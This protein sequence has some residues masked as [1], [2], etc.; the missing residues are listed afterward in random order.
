MK[1]RAIFLDRDGTIIRDRHFL[2]KPEEV[3]LF[4]GAAKALRRLGEAGFALVVL[5]NQSGVA[6]GLF[7]LAAVAAV[8]DELERQLAQEGISLDG[9]YVCPHHP[10]AESKEFGIACEC[11]K[12]APGLA[13]QAAEELSLN[14]EGSWIVGDKPDDV[15]LSKVLPLHAVL[16]RTGYGR[17]REGEV[18]DLAGLHVADDLASAVDWILEREGRS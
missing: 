15:L 14:L 11:R 16:L 2:H 17:V 8:N 1:R 7:D 6:R 4:P 18:A 13:M 5:S 12:P 3:E 10:D 9:I